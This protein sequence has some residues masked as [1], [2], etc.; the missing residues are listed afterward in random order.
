METHWVLDARACGES[1]MGAQPHGAMMDS[2]A[3]VGRTPINLGLDPVEPGSSPT[4]PLRSA[5]FEKISRK[6]D[7]IDGRASALRAKHLLAELCVDLF[8]VGPDGNRLLE[9]VTGKNSVE[10]WNRFAAAREKWRPT[11]KGDCD[12]GRSTIR[13]A[14]SLP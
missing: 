14:S 5:S 4:R 6:V 11:L 3:F 1:A 8:V 2:V 13:E 10:L 12:F 7:S 9:T